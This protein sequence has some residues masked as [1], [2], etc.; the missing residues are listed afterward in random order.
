MLVHT[1]SQVAANSA[2][3]V[4]QIDPWPVALDHPSVGQDAA[5]AADG[6][7][8]RPRDRTIATV[9]HDGLVDD[10][11][12]AELAARMERDQ[13]ARAALGQRASTEA[14]EWLIKVDS[15][16]T[17]WLRSVLDHMGWPG[18]SLVGEQG[19]QAAW[20]L[21]QHADHDPEFQ[22]E[23]LSRL[24]IAVAAC[25]AEPSHLAYL[26][27]RVRCAQGK[28]QVYGTQFWR[29]SDAA[30]PLV[31]QPI[32]DEDLLDERRAALGLGP[33]AA[34]ADLMHERYGNLD[35]PR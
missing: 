10:V 17:A 14:V 9:V 33:F 18:R 23:C 3:E 31:A 28:P 11:L 19:A 25:E 29:G 4:D 24:A 7:P 35:H 16:N 1:H 2:S 6:H 22:Q 12:A 21:A 5:L 15:E 27:D 8:G 32:E 26:T 20:L 30:G 13:A 34:Y